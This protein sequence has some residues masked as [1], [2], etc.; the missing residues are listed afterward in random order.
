MGQNHFAKLPT[1]LYGVVLF[2]A[3]VA[4]S[5]LQAAIIKV[6]GKNSKLR[7]AVGKDRKGKA[8]IALYLVAIA[9]AF[10]KPWLATGLYALVA[11]FWLIPDRR[12][13]SALIV[14]DRTQQSG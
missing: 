7:H 9:A 10:W 5:I 13:E 4:Y 6:Q 12:I 2:L 11:L 14:S 1:A 3:A 8:S